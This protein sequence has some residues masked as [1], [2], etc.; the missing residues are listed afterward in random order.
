V[1]LSFIHPALAWGLLA[2]LAPVAVHLF[3]RRRPRPTPFPAI[4]FILRAR[5]ETER[6]LRLKRILLFAARTLLLAAVA[7]ALARPRLERPQEAAA[8]ARGPSA[9]AIVLDASASMTYRLHGHALFETARADALEALDGLGADEPASA[10]VC[11]GLEAPAA[12]APTFDRA[13][14]RR[15]LARAEPTLAHS[16][17]SACVAAAARGLSESTTG[18]LLGKRIVVATDLAAS[19]WRLDVPAPMVQT[20]QGK[21]RPEVTLLDAAR[22]EALPN[23]ALTELAAEPDPAVGPRGF[24]VTATVASFG[25]PPSGSKGESASDVELQLRAG[26]PHAPVAIR[27]FAQVPPGGAAKKA[28][29]FSFPAG[30]PAALSVTLAHDA[31]EMDDAR[32][33]TVN[34]PR[35]VKALVVNGAPSVVKYRDAAFFVEAALSSPASPVKAT[36]VDAESLEKV[37]LADFDVVLLLDVRS[38]GAKAK[39]LVEF[40]ERGG[41]LFVAMGDEVDPERYD[42]ELGALLPRPLHLVKTA[43]EPPSPSLPPPGGGIKGGGPARFADID[44]THPALQVFTGEAREGFEG[45]RIWKYMLLKP[46]EKKAPGERVIASYDDGAPALVEARRGQGRVILYTSTVDREW[47]DWTIRTSFLPAVQRLAAW[48]AG[49]LDARRDA[50][51]LVGAPRAIG[52]GDGQRLVAVVGPDG[53]ER[54]AASLPRAAEGGAP[55][56]VPDRPGLWSVKVEERG[57]VRLAPKLAFAALPD[58]R[59]SDTTRLDPVE[60][61]AYFGGATHARVS[62]S[63][64]AGGREVPLWSLLLALGLAAFLAEGLLLA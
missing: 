17:M 29:A 2:A 37:R 8:A 47:S 61:T 26:P 60:L 53:R 64:R 3:F 40:V 21:V 32:V 52:A 24:R 48:L 18:A 51:S 38:L 15:A 5:R 59:E 6:R 11:G 16:D 31:L 41:G 25:R 23:V 50:P 54:A 22:G 63:E 36:V 19:A 27:A 9:V 34:V 33:L 39:E 30:G 57:Q 56:V 10:V 13:A 42:S 1:R 20:P 62:S 7:A 55:I 46:V 58:A 45:V 44:W 28:L 14:V 43:A 4:D 49:G 35:E 12:P